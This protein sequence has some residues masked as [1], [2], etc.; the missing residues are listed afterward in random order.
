MTKNFSP[1]TEMPSD[2]IDSYVLSI[3]WGLVERYGFYSKERGLDKVGHVLCLNR[4]AVFGSEKHVRRALKFV[5]N[6]MLESEPF[7]GCITSKPDNGSMVWASTLDSLDGVCSFY[8]NGSKRHLKFL[9]HNMLFSSKE[10]SLAA[11]KFII[12]SL[13]VRLKKQKLKRKLNFLTKEPE[14]GTLVYAIS[15]YNHDNLLSMKFNSDSSVCQRLL[16]SNLLYPSHE[17][18]KH[19][20]EYIMRKLNPNVD[21]PNVDKTTP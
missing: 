21:K 2:Y 9:K 17:K 8:F 4:G 1:L 18:A 11:T 13:K 6:L 12:K 14:N 15:I 20:S 10:D 5:F 16:Q 7:K 3:G 19:A